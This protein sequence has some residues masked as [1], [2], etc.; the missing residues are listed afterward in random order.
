MFTVYIF[1]YIDTTAEGNE[2][3]F[4]ETSAN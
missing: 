3:Q 1:S 4:R 2:L